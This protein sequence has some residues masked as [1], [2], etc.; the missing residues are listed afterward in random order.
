MYSDAVRVGR[1]DGGEVE[2]KNQK[3]VKLT[4]TAED[5]KDLV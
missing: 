2:R 4:S 1:K 3:G 5:W